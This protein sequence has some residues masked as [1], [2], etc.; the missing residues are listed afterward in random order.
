MADECGS[1]FPTHLLELHE[2][3]APPQRA[4]GGHNADISGDN[5]WYVGLWSTVSVLSL[6]T[7]MVNGG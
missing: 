5:V 3:A 1:I 6:G 7:S 2:S 4:R